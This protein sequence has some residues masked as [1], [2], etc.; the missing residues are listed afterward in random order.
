MKTRMRWLD[1]LFWQYARLL[2][3]Q[4]PSS[5]LASACVRWSE[6]DPEAH[7]VI[8]GARVLKEV[9][10]S[11]LLCPGKNRIAR[12]RKTPSNG[13]KGSGHVQA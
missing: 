3:E 6:C 11:A 5:P 4:G 7:E 1:I 9:F 2:D 13:R 12:S 10:G 8:L